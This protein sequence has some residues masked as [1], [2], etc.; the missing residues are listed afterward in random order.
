MGNV[1][2]GQEQEIRNLLFLPHKHTVYVRIFFPCKYNTVWT[3]LTHLKWADL[4]N[5]FVKN[6][7]FYTSGAK[8][9]RNLCFV[10]RSPW[11]RD[12]K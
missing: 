10:R 5:V 8:L 1:D 9:L 2:A 3:V 11:Q 6:I 4:Y 7:S 12:K